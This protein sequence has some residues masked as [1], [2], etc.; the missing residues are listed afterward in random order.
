MK[1]ITPIIFSLV[2]SINTSCGSL[3]TED[4]IVKESKKFEYHH[5]DGGNFDSSCIDRKAEDFSKFFMV[6]K[7]GNGYHF[8]TEM[9]GVTLEMHENSV[10]VE[11]TE[12]YDPSVK[13]VGVLALVFD[14]LVVECIAPRQV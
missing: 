2:V 10:S 14:R 6:K 5:N 9:I 1:K 3:Y 11:S 7:L 12:V 13:T 8:S 4:E